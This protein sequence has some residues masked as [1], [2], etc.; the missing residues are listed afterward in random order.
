MS[1]SR[2]VILAGCVGWLCT[3]GAGAQVCPFGEPPTPDCMQPRVIPGYEGQHVVLMD[4]SPVGVNNPLCQVQSGHIVWFEVTPEVGGP[5]TITTCHPGTGYDTVLEVW[6]GGDDRCEFMTP[7][8]CNDDTNEPACASGCSGAGSRVTVEATSGQRYRFAVGSYN[9]NPTGCPLCLGVIVTVGTPCGVAPTNIT[10]A[11]ARELSGAPGTQYD[12][13]D[14]QDAFALPGQPQPTCTPS[15]FGNTVWYGV[16]PAVTGPLTFSTCLP[17]TN[18]DTVV[19]AYRGDCGGLLAYVDCIDDTF[20]APECENECTGRASRMTLIAH[21]GERYYFQVASYPQVALCELCLGVQVDVV[22]ACSHDQSGPTAQLLAPPEMACVCDSV[23]VMGVADDPDGTFDRF[24]LE[25][26]PLGG[27]GWSLIA[28]GTAPVS[29]GL[30]GVWSTAGLGEGWYLLRLAVRDYCGGTA[31]DERVVRLDAGFDSLELRA[32]DPGSVV[33]G[34]VCVDGTAWDQ[35]FDLYTLQWRPSAGGMGQP[36]EPGVPFYVSTVL[37]DPL[38]RWD[39]AAS[40]VPDGTYA[41]ELLGRTTCGHE[42]TRRTQVTVDNTPPIA[43]ISEPA[44]CVGVGGVVMV[45]GTA[46]DANL[47]EWQ[48]SVTGGDYHGWVPLAGGGGTMLD[49]PLAVWDTTGLRPCAYTL[50]LVV[51]DRAVRDCNGAFRN[52]TEYLASVSVGLVDDF[53]MDNDGDVDLF[54]YQAFEGA[55][56][57]PIP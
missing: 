23:P 27:G 35:C 49:E 48:L 3:A 51:A 6:E 39:T 42:D 13:V 53:D 4:V 50:R 56:T 26:R 19:Q 55:F 28:V 33:G 38:G 9:G 14:A 8:D 31:V 10:C 43:V 47:D 1:R 17:E 15:A 25:V 41:L 16:T 45:R 44:P 40:G 46:L 37:N 12:F 29:G 34:G 2:V 32:P 57:G 21:A 11:T 54:D 22:D 24:V 7:E 30:L 18:Y 5:M 36:V 20:G 52:V